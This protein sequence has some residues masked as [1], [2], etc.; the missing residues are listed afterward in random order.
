MPAPPT[1]AAV[2]GINAGRGGGGLGGSAPVQGGRGGPTDPNA[3]YVGSPAD[4]P[5]ALPGS[6]VV[7]G[8]VRR[9]DGTPAGG[10]EVR[11]ER[12]AD[13]R[14]DAVEADRTRADGAH[15]VKL[16]DGVWTGTACDSTIGYQPTLWRLTVADGR[17][18][19]FREVA[20]AAPSIANAEIRLSSDKGVVRAGDEVTLTGA[21]FRCSGH[22]VV[23]VDG[24]EPVTQG[25]FEPHEDARVSFAFPPLRPAAGGQVVVRRVRFTYVQGPN[26]SNTAEFRAPPI[27]IDA[28]APP[29]IGPLGGG[30]GAPA[31]PVSPGKRRPGKNLRFRK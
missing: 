21:G 26:R 12:R 29:S 6:A 18:L 20:R 3:P 8:T 9:V 1:A 28:L 19:R 13:G 25:T 4:T 16:A 2:G 31:A 14:V 17:I 27:D 7:R 22:V 24:M 23:E 30:G 11:F 5:P 10:V 15:A